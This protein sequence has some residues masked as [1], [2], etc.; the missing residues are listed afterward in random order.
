[1]RRALALLAPLIACAL[2]QGSISG[3]LY[4]P[5]VAGLNVIACYPSE[6][7]CD[8]VLSGYAV[9]AQHGPSASY[10]IDGQGPF[11]VLVWN[12]ADGDGEATDAELSV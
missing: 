4:A 9:I 7:G 2:G 8:E 12:D 1:M 6:T 3:T 10:H 5:S 11:I